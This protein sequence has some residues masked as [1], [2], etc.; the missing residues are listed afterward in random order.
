MNLLRDITNEKEFKLHLKA[1]AVKGDD[2]DGCYFQKFGG[3][4]TQMRCTPYDRKDN[5]NIIWVEVT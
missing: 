1:K 2:C 5:K 4:C 3:G